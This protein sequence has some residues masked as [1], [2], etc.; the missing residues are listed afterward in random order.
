MHARDETIACSVGIDEDASFGAV[1]PPIYLSANYSF[2]GFREP[3]AYDYTRS[4]NPT[5]DQLADALA[6]LERGAGAIVTAS[7]MSAIHLVLSLVPT[8]ALV[9]APHDCYGGTWRLLQALAERKLID[10]IFADLTNPEAL[11]NVLARRPFLVWVETPSNPLMRVTDIRNVV[12]H[13]ETV[14][15]LVAVDNTF[16]SPVLQKPLLLG[17]DFAVHSTTKYLNGHSDVVGG[18][19]IAA[20]REQVEQLA[21]WAN[22]TGVTGAPF[23]AWLTL[24]GLRTLTVRIARQ[25]RSAMA[26]ARFLS[27]HSQV[28]A[29]H[30]PG[31]S[32]DCGR[33]LAQKQQYGFGGML[34][35]EL[36]NEAA[37]KD[38]VG[39]LKVFTL[40]ESLGGVESLVCHPATMTH[41]C[42]SAEAKAA[43]GITPGLLRLS[44]GLEAEWD[45]I[46]DLAQALSLLEKES[47]PIVA[48][49]ASQRRAANG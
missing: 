43:C 34:S 9:A 4:G 24:R 46:G 39:A 1:T 28:K 42:L 16:L 45:L 37:A 49:M 32:S 22:C 25:E 48:Q 29:V 11:A 17:A 2:A 15:A 13:A 30:Y 21:A 27:R 33:A 14:G 36:E 3:R 31:L 18:A 5:R 41:A 19:V 7:G 47:H 20:K 35:F 44:V 40:A 12:A 8:G 6:K 23:D 10:V 26:V 38:V